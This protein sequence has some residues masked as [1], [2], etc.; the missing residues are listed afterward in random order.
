MTKPYPST[1]KDLFFNPDLYDQDVVALRL[2]INQNAIESSPHRHKKGQ[3][4]V[5][6]HG[7]VV[8]KVSDTLWV[9]P[10]QHAMW[11]PAGLLHSN[12]STVNA[13]MTLVFIK[14]GIVEM[15]EESCTLALSPLIHELIEYLAKQQIPY[16]NDGPMARLVRVLLDQ[17][18]TA[19]LFQLHL[20]IS[21]HPKVRL[22]TEKLMMDPSN[23]HTL[24][25]WA[26]ELAM[27]DR[28]LARLIKHET[29][30]TFGRWRQQ[31]HLIIALRLLA[32]NVSVQRVAGDLGYDSVTAFSQMFK[33][34]L[35]KP[36]T[37]YLAELMN[38]AE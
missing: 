2:K 29:G 35:G 12:Q 28:T 6:K 33:K 15:P 31:L 19:P 13:Q 24:K 17:L 22:I 18:T 9:V 38:R 4:V 14:P 37:L 32:S 27:S 36:P 3:L 25:Q 21:K 23:R 7:A 26:D 1:Q 11:V 10:P 8:C 30:F 20:P 16:S 34:A 5:A